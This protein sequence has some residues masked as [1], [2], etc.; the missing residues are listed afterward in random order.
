LKLIDIDHLIHGLLFETSS[1]ASTKLSEWISKVDIENLPY[2]KARIFSNI[3]YS[4]KFNELDE[5][6]RN[7]IIGKT[8]Y[9]WTNNKSRIFRIFKDLPKEL[10]QLDFMLWKGAAV[11]FIAKNWRT[12]EMGDLDVQVKPKELEKVIYYLEKSNNWRPLGEISWNKLRQKMLQ[13]RESWNFI[14]NNGDILDIHWSY[15]NENLSKNLVENIFKSS[16]EVNVFNRKLLVPETEWV[17][18]SSVQHGFLKGTLGDKIQSILDYYHLCLMSNQTKLEKYLTLSGV[19][20][21]GNLIKEVILNKNLASISSLLSFK[22]FDYKNPP[23]LREMSKGKFT[24]F[25]IRTESILPKEN[26]DYKNINN[27]IIYR[28]W[29]RLGRSA[30]IEKKIIKLKGF[31]TKRL[32]K[33]VENIEDVLTI[34]WQL[35]DGHEIWSDR[36][37]CR[38]LIDSLPLKTKGIKIQL[39]KNF[40]ISPNPIGFIYINGELVGAYNLKENLTQDFIQIDFPKNKNYKKIEVSFRPDPY[41]SK[42]EINLRN[43]WQR[44]SI[45]IAQGRF[46]DIIQFI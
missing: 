37:D 19:S 20:E 45:P 42:K 36:A 5:I 16:R 40:K 27:Y 11:T 24:R 14:S 41:V 21:E 25:R 17:I 1:S 39:S 22:L 35:P 38:L 3:I 31:L 30:L 13:R 33:N 29:E 34:G 6:I 46:E 26:M 12:R 23:W 9:T 7:R 28:I 32:D 15:L 18:A 8:R 4:E 43:I 44:Q 10:N 2:E